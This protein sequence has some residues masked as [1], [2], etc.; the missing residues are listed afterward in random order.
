MSKTHGMLPFWTKEMKAENWLQN[1]KARLRFG[2]IGLRSLLANEQKKENREK[3][4][5]SKMEEERQL[6]ILTEMRENFKLEERE[7]MGLVL[8]EAKRLVE[9]DRRGTPLDERR[10][11]REAWI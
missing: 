5:N 1:D 8:K 2:H 7:G 3:R 4:Q 10:R 6:A 11:D 9:R